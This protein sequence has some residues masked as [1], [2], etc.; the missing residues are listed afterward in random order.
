MPVTIL[1]ANTG[2]GGSSPILQPGGMQEAVIVDPPAVT[3]CAT[4]L[5]FTLALAGA[6]EAQVREPLVKVCPERSMIVGVMVWLVPLLTVNVTL[7]AESPACNWIDWI[8]QASNVIGR[9]FTPVDD[10]KR[11]V[12]PGALAVTRTCVIC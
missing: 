1:D 3:P 4:P 8:R 10:A 11:W 7:E 12:I 6:N 9:L 2:I 5:E